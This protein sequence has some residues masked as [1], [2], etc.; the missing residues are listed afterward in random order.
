MEDLIFKTPCQTEREARLNTE[1][2]EV[3]LRNRQS[4]QSKDYLSIT[5]SST[6]L[7]VSRPYGQCGRCAVSGKRRRDK[8]HRNTSL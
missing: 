6:L 5:E 3:V 2:K 4:L 7:G 8:W 1:S